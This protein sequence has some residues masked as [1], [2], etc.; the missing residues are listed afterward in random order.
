MWVNTHELRVPALD[1]VPVS[2]PVPIPALSPGPSFVNN[3]NNNNNIINVASNRPEQPL[4]A[5]GP[6]GNN[7]PYQHAL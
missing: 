1:P 2:V 4:S 5:D 3:N 7:T 6:P